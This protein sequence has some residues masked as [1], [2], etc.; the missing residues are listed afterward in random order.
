MKFLKIMVFA[1]LKHL[2]MVEKTL[3]L[4]S[5]E[6][7]ALKKIEEEVQSHMEKGNEQ[8]IDRAPMRNIPF[9][10]VNLKYLKKNAEEKEK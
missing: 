2:K 8:N 4:V 7:E 1:M 9:M 5:C 10:N 3:Y 6:V